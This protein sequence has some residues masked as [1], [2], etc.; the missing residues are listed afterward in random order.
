MRNALVLVVLLMITC[1]QWSCR[2]TPSAEPAPSAS[3]DPAVEARIDELMAGMSLADKVGEM[4]QVT[5]DVL[6]AREGVR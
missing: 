5:I 1:F 2:S 4:T 3:L 6:L